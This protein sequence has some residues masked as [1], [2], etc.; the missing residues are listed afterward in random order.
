MI[1]HVN[2]NQD[3]YNLLHP[4][5]DGIDTN[6][7]ITCLDSI[8][9]NTFAQF[10][11]CNHKIC[12]TCVDKI[13][14][15]HGCCPFHNNNFSNLQ[16]HSLDKVESISIYLLDNCIKISTDQFNEAVNAIRPYVNEL[17][18]ISEHI[19]DLIT[20]L[21][22]FEMK[23]KGV[24]NHKEE[25]LNDSINITKKLS[26]INLNYL[27]TS[28][29]SARFI[30][31]KY[32]YRSLERMENGEEKVME[33]RKLKKYYKSIFVLCKELYLNLVELKKGLLYKNIDIKFDVFHFGYNAW[34]ISTFKV[35]SNSAVEKLFKSLM[36][37]LSIHDADSKYFMD[38]DKVVIE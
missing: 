10:T 35:V 4:D 29:I 31:F 23:F 30:S 17:I 7:C 27:S 21:I 28:S 14:I 37:S 34:K 26:E 8:I 11:D 12:S 19:P 18:R 1:S 6:R 5:N 3:L 20:L 2:N 22:E 13:T 33:L 24:Q 15:L 25:K 32:I 9:E 38:G 16:M 36:D